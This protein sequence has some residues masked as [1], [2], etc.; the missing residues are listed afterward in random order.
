MRMTVLFAK[1]EGMLQRILDAFVRACRRGKLKVNAGKS[2]VMVFKRAG[3]QTINFA[4]PHR[5]GSE[6]IL[7][8]KI[9]LGKEM[10][11][12]NDCLG[13]SKKGRRIVVFRDMNGKVEKSELTGVVGK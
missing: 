2:K 7:G 5:V 8:C 10:E 3:G 1:S 11:E 6:A 9:W 13:M 12:V 4:K